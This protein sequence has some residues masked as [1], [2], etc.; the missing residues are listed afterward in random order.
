MQSIKHTS[1]AVME[2]LEMVKYLVRF[3]LKNSLCRFGR[4]VRDKRFIRT[5]EF[6]PHTYCKYC[7]I[8]M[9][10]DYRMGWVVIEDE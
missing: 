1:G 7:R 2:R 3:L 8:K 6:R 4:H 9:K 10:K 5:V